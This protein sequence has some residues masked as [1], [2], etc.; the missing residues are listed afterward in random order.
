MFE[1]ALVVV[2]LDHVAR[3]IVNAAHDIAA[4]SQQS[5]WNRGDRTTVCDPLTL[6][7][8][9]CGLCAACDGFGFARNTTAAFDVFYWL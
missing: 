5:N 9:A 2:C 4:V 6:L 1:I 3:C 7:V 8:A